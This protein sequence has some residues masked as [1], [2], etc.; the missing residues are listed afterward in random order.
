MHELHYI[1]MGYFSDSDIIQD[2]RILVDIGTRFFTLL[3]LTPH[4]KGLVYDT[5]FTRLPIRA[6]KRETIHF[7]RIFL[8]W[9]STVHEP[10]DFA[11]PT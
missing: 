11:V 3:D 1:G 4:M 2:I 9:E 6:P 7:R 5:D 10:D 8:S